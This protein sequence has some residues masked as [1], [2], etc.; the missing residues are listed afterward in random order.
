PA[1]RVTRSSGEDV[2]DQA[3]SGQFV[4]QAGETLLVELTGA[5]KTGMSAMDDVVPDIVIEPGCKDPTLCDGEGMV[6]GG[7]TALAQQGTGAQADA[8]VLDRTGILVQ[9]RDADG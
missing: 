2:T 7:S 3:L 4:A 5:Q 8:F 6:A 9:G 1:Q